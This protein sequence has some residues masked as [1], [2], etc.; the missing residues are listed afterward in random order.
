MCAIQKIKP[1]VPY[2]LKKKKKQEKENQLSFGH[3][4]TNELKNG[5]EEV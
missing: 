3:S 5:T 1:E 2:S 4:E